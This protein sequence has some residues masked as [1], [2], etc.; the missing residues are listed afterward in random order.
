MAD[1]MKVY[2]GRRT[3]NGIGNQPVIVECPATGGSYALRHVVRH[4][5]T[6][7]QWGYGGSGP[8]D[9][10]LSILY[11]FCTDRNSAEMFHQ[12]FKWDFV[13]GWEDEWSIEGE[14]INS[15]LKEQWRKKH[16]EHGAEIPA[17]YQ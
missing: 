17:N 5:P 2:K 13:S 8:A 4:S 14:T 16:E 10:A 9:L 6:G 1:R 15:W 7:L 11:D 3:A 12:Q